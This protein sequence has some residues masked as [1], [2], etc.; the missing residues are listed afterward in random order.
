MRWTY[1]EMSA[2]YPV[3]SLRALMPRAAS[4]HQRPSAYA[5]GMTALASKADMLGVH[6][7]SGSRQMP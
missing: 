6:V 4:G 5:S 1:I 3:R 2:F 7:D